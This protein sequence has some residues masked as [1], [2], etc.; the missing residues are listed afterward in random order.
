MRENVNSTCTGDLEIRENDWK[1]TLEINWV[2]WF[3]LKEERRGNWC[4]KRRQRNGAVVVAKFV[5]KNNGLWREDENPL[6]ESICFV[7]ASNQNQLK[8]IPSLLFFFDILGKWLRPNPSRCDANLVSV[9]QPV[10]NPNF[11]SYTTKNNKNN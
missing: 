5:G 2:N 11:H 1:E 6:P 9:S 10:K 7:L 4:A 8:D 3:T